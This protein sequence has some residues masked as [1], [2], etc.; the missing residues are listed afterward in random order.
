MALRKGEKIILEVED[1]SLLGAGV[2]RRDGMVV[3][4]PETVAG[5]RAE[6]VVTDVK[7]RFANA[8]LVRLLEPSPMRCAPDCEAFGQC[9][10]CV[11][12]H[13]PYGE[14]AKIK[15]RALHAAISR[16]APEIRWE[17]IFT[18]SPEQYRNKAVFHVS[19]EGTYGYYRAATHDLVYPAGGRCALLHPDF[20][21]I[22]R[23]TA[24]FLVET[25]PRAFF[26]LALRRSCAGEYTAVLYAE[27]DTDSVSDAARA[28]SAALRK[29]F[30]AVAGTFLGIGA[31]WE[32][33]AVMHPL[34]GEKYLRDR[35]LSLELQISP[36]S[37][38]QVN[39]EIAQALC[40]TVSEYAGLHPGECAADLYC[41]TGTIG[42]T[43]AALAPEAQVIGIEINRDA[44]RDAQ[45]NA[46]RNA[47]PNIRFRAGDSATAEAD[48][49]RFD[50]AV[51]D[52]P[53]RGCSREMLDA[54][55]RLS[56]ERIVYV[57]C[58]PATLARDMTTLLA[59][60]YRAVCARPFDMFPRTEH[61]ECV[62]LLSRE[63][64]GN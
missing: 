9:G 33:S 4:C 40:R 62:V 53:R 5:D 58:N 35:F 20:D 60:G 19:P 49:L 26:A 12:R 43:L 7:K 61:C 39:H 3:F 29:S 41:G 1:T 14:E 44:V 21:R 28:W 64:A 37:F 47:L 13:I 6:A 52:P 56:P 32:D 25:A 22:A 51:I 15:E 30:S 24:D 55:V 54:L 31:P 16:I 46:R 42:M 63:K 10:G 59:A 50:C 17:P 57:S 45:E 23:F 48:G 8:S 36:A 11:F 2:A 38:Y 18:A 34:E 27:K